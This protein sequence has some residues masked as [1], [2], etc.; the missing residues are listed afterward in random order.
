MP[1]PETRPP[2]ASIWPAILQ[3]LAGVVL[4]SCSDTMSKYL[5]QHLPAVEIA[6]LRYV[7]FVLF[8]L[9]FAARR[10]FTGLRPRRASLQVLR[11]IMVLGSAVFFI[12]GLSFMPIAD[13]AAISFVSPALIT[14]LSVLFLREQVGVHRWAA[15]LAGLVGVL[16]VIRPGGGAL[17]WAA[18]YPLASAACWAVG[19]IATRLI[20]TQDRSETTLLW[21]A[22]VGLVLLTLAL[23]VGFVR[24]SWGEVA[25]GLV[26]GGFAST[27]QFLVILAYRRTTASVLAPFS[28]IQ[29][30]A[31]GALGYAVF[32]SVPDAMAFWGAG[33]IVASGLYIVYRE[34]IRSRAVRTGAPA[35]SAAAGAASSGSSA[36]PRVP[37]R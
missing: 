14:A 18:L 25:I 13:A 24:P 16:V 17:Q 2:S 4:F 28:Y 9:G 34:R 22:S 11:A 23:P 36:G 7:V 19:M 31:S 21:S 10:R 12:G 27:G 30:L 35:G 6:W 37:A 26:L 3:V 15:T 29:L 32:G 1:P 33:I 5:R 20:G 8:G